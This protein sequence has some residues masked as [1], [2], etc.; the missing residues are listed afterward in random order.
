M[1][2]FCIFYQFIYRFKKRRVLFPCLFNLAVNVF[3]YFGSWNFTSLFTGIAESLQHLR[4]QV[5]REANVCFSIIRR[6]PCVFWFVLHYCTCF[7]FA[8]RLNTSNNTTTALAITARQIQKFHL[9]AIPSREKVM[10]LIN[11]KSFFFI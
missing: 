3:F 11:Q 6:L 4:P 10:R 7:P 8:N 9:L 2:C 1:Y 5:E